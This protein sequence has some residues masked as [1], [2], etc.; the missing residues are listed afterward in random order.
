[1]T[2]C[3]I[4]NKSGSMLQCDLYFMVHFVIYLEESLMYENDILE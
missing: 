4:L 1:M 2:R 3:L